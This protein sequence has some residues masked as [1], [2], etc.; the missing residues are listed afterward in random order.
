VNVR[1]LELVQMWS[2]TDPAMRA[3]FDFPLHAGAGTKTTA[4]VYFE[5]E[6]GEHLARHADSAEEI[7][8]VVE[9]TG[10]AVVGDERIPLEPGTLGVAAE[11]V[12]HAVYNTGDATLK[13][14]GFFSAAELE[15]TFDEPFQ[16]VGGRVVHTPM[17]EVP[18]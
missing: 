14:I 17:A 16:P 13:I 10:E 5:I 8:Y 9:G 11:L 15:H 7:L 18:A 2:D 1:K 6:P 12:P 3:R 4:A